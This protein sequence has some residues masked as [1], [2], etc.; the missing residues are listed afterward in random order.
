MLG[1]IGRH[2]SIVAVA[3]A[4]A[5]ATAS[6]AVPVSTPTVPSPIVVSVDNVEAVSEDDEGL[7]SSNKTASVTCP[8]GKV[9]FGA[10]G[11]IGFGYGDTI[12]D[13][14]VPSSNLRTVTVEGL[15]HGDNPGNWS[16]TAHAVCADPVPDLQRVYEQ[17]YQSTATPKNVIARCPYGTKV[18]GLG[19]E[20]INGG[21]NVTL[22]DLD[23][24]A[25]LD[26]VDV[27]AYAWHGTPTSN[28]WALRAYAICG[29]PASTMVRV[30]GES[31]S[32][33]VR[34]PSCPSGT[35]LTG[36]GGEMSGAQGDAI[37]DDLIPELAQNRTFAQGQDLGAGAWT[38]AAYGV[39]AS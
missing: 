36:M 17:T 34:S 11:A 10:G 5:I 15:E 18:Y 21:G 2:G 23:I 33:V 31:S 35:A 22:D 28:S 16:V 30:R 3:V 12:L 13:E 38:I 20:I 37:F 7:S 19:A 25:S 27:G 6:P 8:A 14:I 32:G 4:A 9:V 39:C 24:D 26:F 1:V 29:A